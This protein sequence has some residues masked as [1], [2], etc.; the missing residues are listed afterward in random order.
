M[1]FYPSTVQHG[2]SLVEMLVYLAL[3]ILISVVAVSSLFNLT[4]TLTRYRAEKVLTVQS[5][6]MLERMVA[7][8]RNATA[9]DTVSSTFDVSPGTLV[10]DYIGA[11]ITYT[12]ASGDVTVALDTN[13]SSPLNGGDVTVDS[14][15][16]TYYDNMTTELVRIS[17]TATAVVGDTTVT[18]TFTTSAV[19]RGSYE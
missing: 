11:S 4:D 6:A 17:M 15:A 16:F 5:R 1:R 14:L 12:L 10:L 13:P 19:L 8:V 9:V 2:F 3:L 18:E 7:D